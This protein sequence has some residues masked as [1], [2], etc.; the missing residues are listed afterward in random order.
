M[1]VIP[2]RLPET[3]LDFGRTILMRA[4]SG[5]M[6][7]HISLRDPSIP[8]TMSRRIKP[9]RD[10]QSRLRVTG[11]ASRPASQRVW[12]RRLCGIT[13]RLTSSRAASTSAMI[14]RQTRPM[15]ATRSQSRETGQDC[16]KTALAPDCP[17]GPFETDLDRISQATPQGTAAIASEQE[18]NAAVPIEVSRIREGGVSFFQGGLMNEGTMTW[19]AFDIE[20]RLFIAVLGSAGDRGRH[21]PALE[22]LSPNQRLRYTDAAG[23]R[24]A[25]FVTVAGATPAQVREF[26]CLANK[27]L[28]AETESTPRPAPAD[29]MSKSFTLL[30]RGKSLDLG[31]G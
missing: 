23:Y 10:I 13:G 30:H 21:I 4:W 8:V 29:T 28:A 14:S 5:Q 25:E 12:T 16:G 22:K 7:K 18:A 26:G 3:G 9:T 31:K 11:P 24:R 2:R 1:P 19:Y 27:L 20:R 15:P 17:D 6:A